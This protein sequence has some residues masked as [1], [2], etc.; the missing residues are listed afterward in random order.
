M[1][2]ITGSARGTRLQAP[3][4]LATRPTS[5]M[6]KEGIFSVLHF[7][8]PEAMVLDLFAGS[9]QLG[10]EAL[11]RGARAAVLVDSSREAQEIIRKNL[12]AAKLA[13]KARVAAMEASSYLAGC[14]E[15]FDIV[16]L[17]PPY[18]QK[19]IEKVLPM[20]AEKMNPGGVI[21]CETG[22]E[23]DE[24]LPQEAGN[25]FVIH[26][27]YRYGRARVTTYRRPQEEF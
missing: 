12:A 2:V 9:G 10:I 6:A 18:G 23:V 26:R 4:G 19:L 11:S 5:D 22:R 8:V 21:V 17:D 7:E 20:V 3:E 27:T 15:R 13:S 24:E 1:R 25:G 16:F 14:R